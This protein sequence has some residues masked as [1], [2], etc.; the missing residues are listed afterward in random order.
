MRL[1]EENSV[2]EIKQP[3]V[4]FFLFLCLMTEINGTAIHIL[5]F[6]LVILLHSCSHH[7]ISHYSLAR[8]FMIT[9]IVW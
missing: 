8:G 5:L 9:Y 2:K 4:F 1:E 3:D 6:S 7:F